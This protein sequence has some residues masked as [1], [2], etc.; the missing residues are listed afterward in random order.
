VAVAAA[1]A[2][3]LELVLHA[4]GLVGLLCELPRRELPGQETAVFS[5]EA[6]SAPMQKAPYKTVLL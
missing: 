6:P 4:G 3:L 5:C 2:D 1:V